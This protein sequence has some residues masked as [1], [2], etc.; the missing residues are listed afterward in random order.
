MFLFLSFFDRLIT[1]RR[2]ID[3]KNMYCGFFWV[4]VVG[5]V[6]AVGGR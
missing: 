4:N 6:Y 1:H 5:Y 3:D 2:G